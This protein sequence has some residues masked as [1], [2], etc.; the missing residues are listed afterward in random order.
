MNILPKKSWHV[1]TRKNIERVQRDEA[2]AE[3]LANI[4]RDRV[5]RAEQEARVREL[6]IRAGIHDEEQDRR[7]HLDLFQNPHEAQQSSN[8]DH[9]AEQRQREASRRVKAGLCNSLTRPQDVDKPWYCGTVRNQPDKKTSKSELITSIY[10]PMT[11]IRHAE[12]TVRQ[13]RRAERARI[14]SS[15]S[16]KVGSQS[17]GMMM[18]T[19][20]LESDSSPEIVCEIKT[21][22]KTKMR[23]GSMKREV[24]HSHSRATTSND[25]RAIEER[26]G[27][28]I[29]FKRHSE[30]TKRS[31]NRQ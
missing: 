31:R 13:R 22:D 17:R 2:E 6:R 10:D 28:E 14:E 12:Q 5:L 20:T 29:K 24:R 25:L 8:P 26:R 1:R 11:A 23:V 9:E 19:S 4:E 3:R 18:R 27:R 16:T 21:S 15:K 7:Q 30:E